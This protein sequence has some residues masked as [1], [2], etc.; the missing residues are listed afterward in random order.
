[1]KRIVLT[2][3]WPAT[4]EAILS[5]RYDAVL[6]PDDRP[7]SASE[8]RTALEEADAVLTTVTDRL[9]A[10]MLKPGIRA[11]ILGNFGVG[12]SHIDLAAAQ[13]AGL[14]VVNTPGVL[15]DATA[16]IGMTLLLM[17]AR[18]ASEGEAL[19]RAGKWTGWTPTQLIGSHVTGKTIGI[20]GMGRIGMAMARRAHYGF[21]MDVVFHNRSKVAETGIPGARQL[22]LEEV[23]AEADFLSLHCPGGAENRHLIDAAA[24]ARMKPTAH[25]INT[26]RGEVVDEAALVAA[27]KAGKLAGAGL[28]VF[29]AEPTLHP[30]LAGLPMVSL[31]PHLGSATDETRHAMGMKVVDNLDAFFAGK[32]PPDLC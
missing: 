2:R 19:V 8:L 14:A 1:M 29:E 27:L 18:R 24:L 26:A 5:E 28:D 30:E 16:D 22:P 12:I 3:R 25:L 32:T 6:N 4:V 15:T 11:Q 13:A 10:D 31:L 17:T 23:L 7:L 21:G 20:V 9:D